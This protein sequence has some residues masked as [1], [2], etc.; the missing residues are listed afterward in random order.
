M[1]ILAWRFCRPITS[2]FRDT[3]HVAHPGT[4]LSES[5]GGPF[6]FPKLGV[7]GLKLQPDSTQRIPSRP[8]P[9]ESRLGWFGFP[10]AQLCTAKLVIS[11]TSTWLSMTERAHT[12]RFTKP[13]GK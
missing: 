6:R 5:P 2:R 3:W 9:L 11:T 13:M 12:R 10:F 1:S 7:R 4:E 8:P